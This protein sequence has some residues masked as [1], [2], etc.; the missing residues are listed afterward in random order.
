M[1]KETTIDGVFLS[2]LKKD[3]ATH[4]EVTELK[5][6]DGFAGNNAFQPGFGCQ[7]LWLWPRFEP[8]AAGDAVVRPAQVAQ[9]RG[10]IGDGLAV[11]GRGMPIAHGMDRIG[12]LDYVIVQVETGR[13][14]HLV[15]QHGFLLADQLL[16]P[17]SQVKSLGT[18][19]A[20]ATGPAADWGVGNTLPARTS[21]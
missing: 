15:I 3:I 14:T 1:M 11:L 9:Q 10:G 7:D 17:V 19:L 2:V 4:P 21:S 5:Q 16:I 13:I 8:T 20:L 6:A 12:R 18:H